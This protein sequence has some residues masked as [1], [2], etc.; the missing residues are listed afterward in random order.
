MKQAQHFRMKYILLVSIT[1]GGPLTGEQHQVLMQ[2]F[3]SKSACE[4][5][6]KVFRKNGLKRTDCLPYE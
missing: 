1:W 6:R 5:A 3:G 2:E 4:N